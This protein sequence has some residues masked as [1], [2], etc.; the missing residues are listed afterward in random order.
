MRSLQ[1]LGYAGLIPFVT[2]PL[3]IWLNWPFS[4]A[5][6]LLGF[7]L[8]SCLILGFMAGVLWP[9]LHAKDTPTL[10]AYLAVSFPVLSF[11]AWMI[12]P[13]WA[14]W[15]Q[16]ALFFLLRLT[17]IISR[18]DQAYPAGYARLRWHLTGVVVAAHLL[19][20]LWR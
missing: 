2:L 3:V 20:A 11:I 8:Y 13:T 9:A 7:Q 4:A 5:Q 6:A 12:L 15:I 17:E 18:L 14:L 10:W 16:A 19:V 1:L